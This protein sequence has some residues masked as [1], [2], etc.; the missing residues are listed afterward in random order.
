MFLA[1]GSTGVSCRRLNSQSTTSCRVRIRNI[2]FNGL[3]SLALLPLTLP[4]QCTGLR[5]PFRRGLRRIAFHR[6]LRLWLLNSINTHEPG[7]RHDK[8]KLGDNKHDEKEHY[9]I[10]EYAGKSKIQL[11]APQCSAPYHNL[12][13]LS[14][15]WK[16]QKKVE[17]VQV[18]L[19]VQGR[20]ICHTLPVMRV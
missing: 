13:H 2:N 8:S 9:N 5:C 6:H 12:V 7:Q 3:A 10:P 11:Q 1:G 19:T 17:P 20:P 16:R 4:K 14:L 15:E 18:P